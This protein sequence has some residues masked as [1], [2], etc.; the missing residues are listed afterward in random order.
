[1]SNTARVALAAVVALAVVALALV[2]S[3]W[4]APCRREIQGYGEQN[5]QKHDPQA[6][7]AAPP[8]NQG[9]SEPGEYQNDD[10]RRTV[11]GGHGT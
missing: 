4:P 1:M 3:Q 7:H 5:G 9:Q 8:D 6:D 10:G 2:G 11:G